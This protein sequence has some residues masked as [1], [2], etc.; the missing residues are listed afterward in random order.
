MAFY[1][2]VRVHVGE[3]ATGDDS[4]TRCSHAKGNGK[5][6]SKHPKSFLFMAYRN[7]VLPY[8]NQ[9]NL[10][11]PGFGKVYKEWIYSGTVEEFENRWQELKEKFRA[12]V[13]SWLLNLYRDRHHWIQA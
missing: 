1:D 12:R 8:L 10:R 13:N 9:M 2:L 5:G 4:R 11:F 3:D 6:L 7:N